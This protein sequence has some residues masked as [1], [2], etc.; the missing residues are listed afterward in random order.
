MC[1]NQRMRVTSPLRGFLASK[2]FSSG[3]LHPRLQ[4]SA[5]ARLKARNFKARQRRACLEFLASASDLKGSTSRTV[6]KSQHHPISSHFLTTQKHG[7]ER[8][9]ISATG[10]AKE[11]CLHFRFESA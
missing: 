2:A 1:G 3:D 4:Y 7:R 9:C 11:M 6:T 10:A 5:A 8:F